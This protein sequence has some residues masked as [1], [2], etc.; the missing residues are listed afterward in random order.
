MK[1]QSPPHA[2]EAQRQQVLR[3][4]AAGDSKA[5]IRLNE[6][7][8]EEEDLNRWFSRTDLL[9]A[10]VNANFV[11]LMQEGCSDRSAHPA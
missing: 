1:T 11:V 10:E 2:I 3:A 7:E 4:H 5:G 9:I 8:K 6:I